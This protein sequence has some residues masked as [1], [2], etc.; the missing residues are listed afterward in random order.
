MGCPGTFQD[1]CEATGAPSDFVSC[2][3]FKQTK[4]FYVFSDLSQ[5]EPYC[6]SYAP[7]PHPRPRGSR[8][9]GSPTRDRAQALGSE[10]AES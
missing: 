3:S 9:L 4:Y 1:T 8:D 5:P 10:R 7:L 6:V 2:F